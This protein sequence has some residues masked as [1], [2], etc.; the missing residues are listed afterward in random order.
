MKIDEMTQRKLF[1]VA[2]TCPQWRLPH[3]TQIGEIFLE[4]TCASRNFGMNHI[5]EWHC[6][7]DAKMFKNC[8]ITNK[9]KSIYFLFLATVIVENS[10][11]L[12]SMLK[13]SFPFIFALCSKS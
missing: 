7:I 9:L 13:D 5:L 3:A 11:D 4:K 2:F 6:E 8:V 12:N 10:I 1:L